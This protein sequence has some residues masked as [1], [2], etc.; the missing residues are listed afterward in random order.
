M[1]SLFQII[2]VLLA[3][4]R[5]AYAQGM[6]LS[7]IVLVMGVA[8]LAL[9]GWFI[10]AAAAAGMIGLGTVFNAVSYTI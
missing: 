8:L 7:A 9:S 2:R 5:R 1:R 6:A 10:T 4:E 3:G